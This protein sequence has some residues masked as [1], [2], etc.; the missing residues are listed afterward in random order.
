MLPLWKYD[1]RK[2]LSFFSKKATNCFCTEI[3][4]VR[5][6]LDGKWQNIICSYCNNLLC[7]KETDLQKIYDYSFK[8]HW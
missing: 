3:A 1:N 6:W 2:H 4:F 8:S 7:C 5:Q